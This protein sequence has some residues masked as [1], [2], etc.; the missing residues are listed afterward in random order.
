MHY[1]DKVKVSLRRETGVSQVE[2]DRAGGFGSADGS[3]YI[4]D[5]LPPV[6]LCV[7]SCHLHVVL[8]KR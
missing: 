7:E 2:E 6:L 8:A 3:V 1:V 4:L 5:T